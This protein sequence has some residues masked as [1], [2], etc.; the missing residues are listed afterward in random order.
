MEEAAT[1]NVHPFQFNVFLRDVAA[2]LSPVALSSPCSHS[3]FYLMTYVAISL[4]V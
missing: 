1:I 3:V 2:R 4:V